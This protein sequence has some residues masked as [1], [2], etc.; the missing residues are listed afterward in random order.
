M[1]EALVE[2]FAVVKQDVSDVLQ[3][4]FEQEREKATKDM[5]DVVTFVPDVAKKA[6]SPMETSGSDMAVAVFFS[7]PVSTRRP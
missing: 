4:E 2:R 3:R 1:R 6:L 5:E 7:T